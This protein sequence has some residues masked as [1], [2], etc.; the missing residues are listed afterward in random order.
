MSLPT[1]MDLC[2]PRRRPLR[3]FAVRP[4]IVQTPFVNQEHIDD[5]HSACNEQSLYHDIKCKHRVKTRYYEGCGQNCT[6]P[7]G[8]SPFIC[9][10]CVT[11]LVR[12][13]MRL[14][15]MSLAESAFDTNADREARVKVIAR[16]EIDRLVFRR[17]RPTVVV[18]RLDPRLQF[19]NEISEAQENGGFLKEPEENEPKRYKRPGQGA[20]LPRAAMVGLGFQKPHR[21]RLAPARP[22]EYHIPQLDGR[23]KA[24]DN[25][26]AKH[27]NPGRLMKWGPAGVAV[28]DVDMGDLKPGGQKR[29]RNPPR[30][31]PTRFG[32]QPVNAR[33]P[34]AAEDDA[35]RVVREI[36]NVLSLED[37][38]L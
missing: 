32:V 35:S 14:E 16:K 23:T 11:E 25:G 28:G 21:Q 12:A 8:H 1:R 37:R 5:T 27:A 9:P 29:K 24:V 26:T 20:R 7:D 19:F 4:W 34:D 15:D 30:A 33:I 31:D 13:G 2:R 38:N 17:H 22:P 6:K 10:E 3:H 36:L 18:P